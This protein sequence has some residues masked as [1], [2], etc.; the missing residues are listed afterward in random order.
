MMLLCKACAGELLFRAR[1]AVRAL[2][3]VWGRVAQGRARV[4]KARER[5]TQAIDG[6]ELLRAP[7]RGCRN[8]ESAAP[9]ARIIL[10]AVGL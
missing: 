8:K 5:R 6:D 2:C 1:F 7:A 10:P 4:E 9:R 3:V